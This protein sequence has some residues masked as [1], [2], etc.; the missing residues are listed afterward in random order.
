MASTTALAKPARS[1][2]LPVPK[3]K[4]S[5]STWRRVRTPPAIS[6]II[7]KLHSAITNQVRRSLRSWPS[8]RK[9][10]LWRLG[11][12][13]ITIPA[14]Y[15]PCRRSLQ[16]GLHR[17][18][19]FLSAAA[20]LGVARRID[21]VQPNMVFDHLG[22]KARKRAARCDDEMQHIGT[23][24]FVFERALDR[25]DLAAHP[26]HAVQELELFAIGVGQG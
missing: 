18:D 3:L 9:T 12:P 17:L 19:Q 2:S 13:S 21:N 10:W 7:M 16:I 24:L 25:F 1:P 5:S 11:M 23:A 14:P 26:S 15:P 8:P 4:R 20:A 22:H 6:A